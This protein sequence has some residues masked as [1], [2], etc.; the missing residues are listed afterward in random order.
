MSDVDDRHLITFSVRLNSQMLSDYFLRSE[1]FLKD[2]FV[3]LADILLCLSLASLQNALPEA[4]PEFP[5]RPAVCLMALV[6]LKRR[7]LRAY[8]L[9]VLCGVFLDAGSYN[10]M[11]MSSLLC[12]MAVAVAR[13]VNCAFRMNYYLDCVLAAFSANCVWTLLR[14]FPFA[15]GMPM[16]ER[17]MLIPL[18]VIISSLMAACAFAPFLFSVHD[19][20]VAVMPKS[21]KN[22][23]KKS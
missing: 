1:N 13:L 6:A 12:V 20:I 7:P 10:Q 19:L 22:S 15:F 23:S 9:A 17:I 8:A 2:A 14:I 5:L 16:H 4:F 3:C 11:G 18:Q 21:W